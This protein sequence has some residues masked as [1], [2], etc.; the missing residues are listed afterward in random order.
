MKILAVNIS[1]SKGVSAIVAA[2]RAWKI[3]LS[4]ATEV[5]H[6]VA[7]ANNKII[8]CF[9]SNGAS[10][11]LIDK[12]R[13]AFKLQPMSSDLAVRKSLAGKNIKYF[14]TKYF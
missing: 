8:E 12:S 7:V 4:G 5:T 9:D 11:D 13:V 6:V 10:L 3:K 2:S 14:T 1:K